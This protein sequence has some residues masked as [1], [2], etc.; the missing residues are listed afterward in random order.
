MSKFTRSA[1]SNGTRL[2]QDQKIDPR[3]GEARRLK[4]LDYALGDEVGGFD[5]LGEGDR[6]A[7]RSAAALL[8]RLEQ[9]QAAM[10]RG[11]EVDADLL[12]RLNSEARRALDAVRKRGDR[13]VQQEPPGLVLQHT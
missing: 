2:H 6:W 3:R 12:I 13:S 1:V 5:A 11:Q 8:L 9:L 7:V 4:D 10:A